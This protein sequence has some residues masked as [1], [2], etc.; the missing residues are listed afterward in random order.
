MIHWPGIKTDKTT[1]RYIADQLR[2]RKRDWQAEPNRHTDR[3]TD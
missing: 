1:E 2:G 3:L